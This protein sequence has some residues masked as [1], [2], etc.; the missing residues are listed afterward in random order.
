VGKSTTAAR[1]NDGTTGVKREVADG[2]S[3]S[4]TKEVITGLARRASFRQSV[5]PNSTALGAP[6][7][8]TKAT[9]PDRVN[10][11]S[12]A[13]SVA[14]CTRRGPAPRTLP[15]PLSTVIVNVSPARISFFESGLL[16]GRR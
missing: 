11:K 4:M 3:T 10:A 1:R 15:P 7:Y 12:V 6:M 8:S 2:P 14:D 5:S 13:S 16:L 9:F